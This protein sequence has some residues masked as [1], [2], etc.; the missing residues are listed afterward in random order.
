[1]RRFI[2]LNDSAPGG[3]DPNPKA[4]DKA[5]DKAPDEAA[6]LRAK[7]AEYEAK[8]AARADAERKAA[9]DAAKKRGDFEKI[10]ADKD[11]QIGKLS[12][13]EKRETA[14]LKRVGEKVEAK[15]KSLPKDRQALIPAVLLADPDAAADYLETNWPLLSGQPAGEGTDR[16]AAKAAPGEMTDDKVP[17]DIA[18]QAR[19]RGMAPAAW[20]NVL[21]KAGRIKPAANA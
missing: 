10:I 3:G 7:L 15:I 5:G 9:E 13:L 8:D 12:E 11:A 1:M 17:A 21:L 19:E 6:A 16:P 14:R 18:A 2:F 4:G 20:Y